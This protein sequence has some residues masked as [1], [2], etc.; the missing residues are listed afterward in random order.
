MR[1]FLNSDPLNALDANLNY[2]AYEASL[3]PE[4][5]LAHRVRATLTADSKIPRIG[6]RGTA[7][8]HGKKVPIFF[9]IMRRPFSLIRTTFG[10]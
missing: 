1:V 10:L 5:F 3:R 4:G 6:Q 7:R 2:L 8:I 9:W